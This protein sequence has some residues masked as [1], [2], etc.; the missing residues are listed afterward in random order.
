MISLGNFSKKYMS[1]GNISNLN[2]VERNILTFSI[3]D[4]NKIPRIIPDIVAKKPIVKP[5][6]KRFFY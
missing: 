6:K 5:V 1:L 4:E 2:T 3:F